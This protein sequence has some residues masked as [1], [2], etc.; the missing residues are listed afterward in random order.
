[1]LRSGFAEMHCRS[2]WPR[3]LGPSGLARHPGSARP[4][5]LVPVP[6]RVPVA[7][8]NACRTGVHDRGHRSDPSGCV[9]TRFR[10][11][12]SGDRI[13]VREMRPN[14]GVVLSSCRGQP[15]TSP[16]GHDPSCGIGIFACLS[17]LVLET[18][19]GPRVL[20]SA[21][22]ERCFALWVCWVVAV[23]GLWGPSE[24]RIGLSEPACSG[25][26]RRPSTGNCRAFSLVP[27]TFDR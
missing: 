16:D 9:G 14:T 11:R 22:A 5:T 15:P 8:H 24:G 26:D 13:V 21:T 18:D 12:Q 2:S 4:R 3:H 19:T 7:A 1:M 6:A 27:A 23:L 17:P 20:P 25:A 10:G